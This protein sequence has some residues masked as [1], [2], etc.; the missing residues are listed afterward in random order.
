MTARRD[1]GVGS[2]LA[3]AVVALGLLLRLAIEPAWVNPDEGIYYAM[4]TAADATRF[5]QGVAENAHPP[6]FYLVL[7]G[8]GQITTDFEWLRAPALVSGCIAI[9]AAYLFAREAAGAHRA[10]AV[11]GL[12]AA[13]AIAVSPSMIV[14]SRVMRPYTMQVAFVLL[15]LYGLARYLR[16]RSA[17]PLVLYS[18]FLSFALLTHYSSMLTLATSAAFLGFLL[19]TRH[20]ERAAVKP[21]LLAHAVPALLVASLFALH[22][23][24]RLIGSK[25]EESA[26]QGYLRAY[27]ISDTSGI[28]SSLAGTVA[29]FAARFAVPAALLLVVGLALAV[30]QRRVLVVGL[31]VAAVVVAWLAAALGRYPFGFCRQATYAVGP[32]MLPFAF[33][34]GCL[35]TSGPRIAAA[36]VA[37]LAALGLAHEPLTRALGLRTVDV[38]AERPLLRRDFDDIAPRLQSIRGRSG[39]VIMS[40]QCYY[41]MQPVL[42]ADQ[43][44]NVRE[45][46]GF[47]HLRWGERDV[48]VP[49]DP[50]GGVAGAWLIRVGPDALDSRAHLYNLVRRV[51]ESMPNLRLGQRREVALMFGGWASPAVHMLLGS[52]QRLPPEQRLA[53]KLVQVRG[54]VSFDYDIATYMRRVAAVTGRQR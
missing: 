7:R 51:D 30:A 8:I 19:L 31:T 53:S 9:H 12:L 17:R 54:L 21:L 28:W 50:H 18:L 13:L 10:A 5:W 22:L 20:V 47:L 38:L 46:D 49:W 33:G 37:I 26:L 6:L 36:S 40:G 4:A 3:L 11:T 16:T 2:L 43:G 48:I 34:I 25:L 35:L 32:L 44:G 15:A 39:A 41:L 29:L 14:L 24:P 23:G 27:L 1:R 42:I 45:H 52:D